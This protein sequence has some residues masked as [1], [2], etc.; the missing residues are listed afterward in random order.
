MYSALLAQRAAENRPIRVGLIG[1]GKFGGGVVAQL[2]QLSQMRGMEV[3]VIAELDDERARHAYTV[4]GRL[5]AD[6]LR[7][8]KNSNELHDTIHNGQRAIVDD[9]LLVTQCDL[10]DVVVEATGVPEVGA[11]MAYHAILNRKHVVMVNV[12]ADVTVGA[13]LRRMADSAGVV[14]TLVDGDQP[15]C[16]MNMVEWARA[17]GF[18]IVA[19]GRGTILYTDDPQGTPEGVP[20]RYGFSA[21]MIARRTIN[22]KMYNSFRDGTKAQVEMTA[23]ANAAGLVPDKRGMHEPSVNIQD[24]ARTFSLQ[25]EGGIL[26]QHGV[27]ELANSVAADGKTLLPNGLGMGVFCVIRTDHPFIQEDL[28]AYSLAPGGDHHNYLLYRPY[29]LVAAE[30]PISIMSAVFAGQP[31]GA[32]L[33]TPTAECITVAKRHL[34]EGETLDGGGGYTV[35]GACEKAVVARDQRLL[36]LGLSAGAKLKCD[37]SAGQAITYDM[38]DLKEDSFVL[39]LRRLQEAAGGDKVRG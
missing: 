2:S 17:L 9:G 1:T 3:A 25:R 32:A 6:K 36:P 35:L 23:L 28:Q 24:I 14:Y 16:T 12:E 11:R 15:G 21:E 33:P 38:V 29:H 4:A 7:V 27:V 19:A 8:A 26:S 22:L 31:T 34:E 20:Q 30:A 18:E 5:P 39:K 10:V 37:V 13:I